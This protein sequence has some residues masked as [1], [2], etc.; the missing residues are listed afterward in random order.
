MI[1]DGDRASSAAARARRCATSPTPARTATSCGR[2]RP[3]TRP[4]RT[5]ASG[6]SLRGGRPL[7][8]RG[9][10]RRGVRAA[11]QA[12]YVVHAADGD[13]SVDDRSDRGRRL[14]DARRVRLRRR[15]RPVRSTSP[16]T[17]A[18][19]SRTTSSS[20]STPCAL[21]PRR[22]RRA[23]AADHGTTPASDAAARGCRARCARRLLVLGGGGAGASWALLMIVSCACLPTA[24]GCH[25]GVERRRADH[26]VAGVVVEVLAADVVLALRRDGVRGAADLGDQLAR[27]AGPRPQQARLDQRRVNLQAGLGRRDRVVDEERHLVGPVAQR[28]QVQRARPTASARSR[29]ACRGARAASPRSCTMRRFGPRVEQLRRASPGSAAP[30]LPTCSRISVSICGAGDRARAAPPGSSG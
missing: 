21:T 20:C 6:T 14:A 15:R 17:P 22:R 28:R 4:R 3:R 23:R 27:V 8:G 2:T 1:D 13:T 26:Q 7:P 10:H 19:R 16:T 25:G 5:S 30:S 24:V 18:S 9:L 11:K 29:R 12:N